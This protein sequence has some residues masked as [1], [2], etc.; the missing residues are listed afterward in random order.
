MKIISTEIDGVKIVKSDRFSDNRGS[1]MRLF[2][3]KEL[4]AFLNDRKIVQ[5]NHSKTIK[6]GTIR[7]LHFQ[8]S[9]HAEMKMVR[10]LKGRVFDVAVDLR[11]NSSSYLKWHAEELSSENGHMFIIPE[12]C[13]HGFQVLEADSELLYL[14]TALYCPDSEGGIMHND[15]A[16]GIQWPLEIS[17][18]SER[19]LKY[20]LISQLF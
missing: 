4:N 1:F 9:P 16:I 15:P 11:K 14:H 20:K 13:A 5:I 12:G 18:V 17:E 19:D 6:V 2:C 10:C 3:D 8:N 7:G